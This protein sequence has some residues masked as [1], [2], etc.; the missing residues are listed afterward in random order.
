MN[1][2]VQD[3]VSPKFEVQNVT[4]VA[5]KFNRGYNLSDEYLWK[6]LQK[7]EIEQKGQGSILPN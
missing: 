4:C 1:Q 3:K 2:S 5:P 7:M 6:L